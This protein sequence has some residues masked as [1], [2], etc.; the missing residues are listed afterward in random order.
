MAILS[1][2]HYQQY[3]PNTSIVYH[4][5]KAYVMQLK[6]KA[7]NSKQL[8]H[9]LGTEARKVASFRNVNNSYVREGYEFI[10]S[11]EDYVGNIEDSIPAVQIVS[12]CET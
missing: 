12:E 6:R 7:T 2:S 3:F 5:E 1:Q 8:L 4:Y 10:Y 11:R 9:C